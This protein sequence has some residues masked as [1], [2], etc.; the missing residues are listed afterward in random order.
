MSSKHRDQQRIHLIL[1]LEE[2]LFNDVVETIYN[3]T[4][5]ELSD[6]RRGDLA[7]CLR[8]I[9]IIGRIGRS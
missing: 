1:Q 9:G 5:Q 6:Q 3:W 2:A 7:D 4:G 8:D